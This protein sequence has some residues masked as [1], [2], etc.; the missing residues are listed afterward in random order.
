MLL[1]ALGLNY[2][3]EDDG[4]DL[5]SENSFTEFSQVSLIGIS[6]LILKADLGEYSNNTASFNN[7][8]IKIIY[9][10]CFCSSD[11]SIVFSGLLVETCSLSQFSSTS[12]KAAAHHSIH[13]EIHL[14]W[15]CLIVLIVSIVFSPK[16]TLFVPSIF[17]FYLTN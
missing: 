1:P 6:D 7:S 3:R 13:R 15:F 14:S 17:F 10:I 12:A 16:G 2:L 9:V 11:F 4:G 5:S 8:R